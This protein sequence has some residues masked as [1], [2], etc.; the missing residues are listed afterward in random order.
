M[1]ELYCIN[2][3]CQRGQVVWELYSRAG[4]SDSVSSNLCVDNFF[5]FVHFL[6]FSFISFRLARF[7]LFSLLT[8]FLASRGIYN[9]VFLV[10]YYSRTSLS[11]T[12][13]E[14]TERSVRIRD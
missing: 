10:L 7:T 4:G 8:P 3:Q 11:D 1:V 13:I 9:N 5:F 6:L 2:F 12:D 14:G